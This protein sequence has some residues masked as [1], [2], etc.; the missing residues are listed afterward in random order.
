MRWFGAV[1]IATIIMVDGQ[2]LASEEG[3]RATVAWHGR[4]SNLQQKIET[5]EG[6]NRLLMAD[7]DDLKNNQASV[8]AYARYELSMI[9][10]DETL[11]QLITPH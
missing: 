11:V 9:K 8:E 3:I 6:K 10:Q 2:L 4:I 1:I 5:M 7:I